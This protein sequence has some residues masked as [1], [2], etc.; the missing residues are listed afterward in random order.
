MATDNQN[1]NRDQREEDKQ[2]Y[3]DTPESRYQPDRNNPQRHHDRDPQDDGDATQDFNTIGDDGTSDGIAKTT[4]GSGGNNGG[5][6][7]RVGDKTASPNRDQGGTK[8]AGTSHQDQ[9]RTPSA[10]GP[11]QGQGDKRN[12]ADHG[13]SGQAG[14]RSGRQV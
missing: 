14:S 4:A 10:Q 6:G 13:Q 1:T 5:P 3:R 2:N 12:D 8:G 7:G 9:L 11:H